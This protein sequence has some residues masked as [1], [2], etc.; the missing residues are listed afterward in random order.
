MFIP[1][2]ATYMF[3]P[4]QATC[5][6]TTTVCILYADAT[7][8][9]AAPCMCIAAYVSLG[10]RCNILKSAFIDVF[11]GLVSDDE[12]CA[13]IVFLGMANDLNSNQ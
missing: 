4:T 6:N 1:S 11:Y 9:Y 10:M 12:A 7:R 5:Y 2:Q 3:I 13:R 8:R